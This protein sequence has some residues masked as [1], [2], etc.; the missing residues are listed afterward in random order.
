MLAPRSAPFRSQTDQLPEPDEWRER[1]LARAAAARPKGHRF[2]TIC[3]SRCYRGWRSARHPAIRELDVNPFRAA[4]KRA[5]A[6]AL[7][8]CIRVSNA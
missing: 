2:G 5:D 1:K 3:W 4:S 6:V 7:D 8:V